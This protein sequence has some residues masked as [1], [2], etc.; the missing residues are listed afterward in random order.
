MRASRRAVTRAAGAVISSLFIVGSPEGGWVPETRFEDHF[1]SVA[2]G[3]ARFRP[4]YPPALFA[5]LARLTPEHALAWDCATGNGQAAAGL[6]EHFE[7]V[8]ASDASAEQVARAMPRARVEYRVAPAEASGLDEA[9]VDLVMVAQ[10]V[11]WFDLPA[12][13]AEVRRVLKPG[14]VLA[15]SCY[16]LAR[17]GDAALDAAINR[18]YEETLGRY[19]PP[20]RR[21][22]ESGY[23]ALAFPFEEMAAP[24]FSI[25]AD[26]SLE[27]L[28]GYLRT[29]S[30][31]QRYR[32]ARGDDPVPAVLDA[33]APS[34]GGAARRPVSWP[35][36][37]RLGRLPR[38]GQ[39][40]DRP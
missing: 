40:G 12:F 37:L 21:L 17:F 36:A 3:Y 33:L 35:L 6:A 10:A 31:T 25:D 30:G 14:G 2:E 23:R 13:Y 24:A 26:F 22:I 16:G 9:S 8:I 18:F 32:A 34:W 27:D 1:S 4:R 5:Y 29:W 39:R 20:Q 38:L 11:H 7:R 15:L 19:W 28:G